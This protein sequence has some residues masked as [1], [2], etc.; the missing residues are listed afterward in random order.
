MNP[1]GDSAGAMLIG[2]TN[3]RSNAFIGVRIEM[4]IKAERY[5]NLLG[6]VSVVTNINYQHSF[7]RVTF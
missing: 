6:V 1:Q 4:D 7:D 3:S 5:R 2:L